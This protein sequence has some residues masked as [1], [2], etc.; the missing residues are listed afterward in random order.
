M[1]N[2]YFQANQ[3]AKAFEKVLNSHGY[4]FQYGVLKQAE[5]LILERQ[6][7]WTLSVAEF[8]VEVHGNGTRIDFILQHRMRPLY[9]LAEC[10][11]VNPA[12]SNWCF[13]RAS[14]VPFLANARV[15]FIE[16]LHQGSSDSFSTKTEFL[17]HSDNIYHIAFEVKG[18]VPGDPEG[19]GRGEIEQAATQICRGL[20]GMIDFFAKHPVFFEGF[21]GKVQAIGFLPVIFTTARLW[22]STIDLGSADLSTGNVAVPSESLKELPWLVYHYN[23][24]PGLKHSLQSSALTRT[25]QDALYNEYVRTIAVVSASGIAD[26]LC[27]G[28]FA[29]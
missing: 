22:V 13:A 18:N 19:H 3:F 24:S 1:Q 6:S 25:L 20:N 8:P 16:T 4:G 10:K 29:F 26:F 28:I 11:R 2:N 21:F 12:I 5:K 14:Y 9:I 27:S 23:Q 17:A 7:F 15:A